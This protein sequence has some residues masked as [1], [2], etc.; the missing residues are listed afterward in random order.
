MIVN[1]A[2]HFAYAG[3]AGRAVVAAFKGT[4]QPDGKN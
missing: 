1:A 3:G 2:L 4:V